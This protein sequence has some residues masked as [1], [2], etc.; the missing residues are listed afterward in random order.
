MKYFKGQRVVNLIDVSNG[1]YDIPKKM[2]GTI[3]VI[4]HD[5]TC[6]DIY[7]IRWDNNELEEDIKLYNL[8]EGEKILNFVPLVDY[9]ELYAND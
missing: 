9:E 6:G 4:H 1:E 8:R 5:D 3:E 7:D 2:R